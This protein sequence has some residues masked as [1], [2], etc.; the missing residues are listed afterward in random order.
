M[1][2]LNKKV[3]ELTMRHDYRSYTLSKAQLRRSFHVLTAQLEKSN[4]V[5]AVNVPP[6]SP[7]HLI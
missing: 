1:Q 3:M 2:A 6:L 7:N 5:L 4:T